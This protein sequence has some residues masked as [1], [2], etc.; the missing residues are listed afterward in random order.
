MTKIATLNFFV[1]LPG[2]VLADDDL[3]ALDFRVL[4]VVAAHDRM[5]RNGQCCWAGQKKLAGLANC[6]PTRLSASLSKLVSKGYLEALRDENDKRRKGFRVIYIAADDAP[7]I[8]CAAKADALRNGNVSEE[9]T[10][11]TGNLS[12]RDSLPKPH[13]SA[14]AATRKSVINH[15]VKSSLPNPNIF[16]ETE[17][18][19]Q[20]RCSG[21]G[22]RPTDR[23]LAD[24]LGAGDSAAGWTL[25]AALPD[26][27][28]RMLRDRWAEGA[29]DAGDLGRAREVAAQMH[30][31]GMKIRAGV[32]P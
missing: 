30:G 17:H 23:A 29:L 8:G 31:S 16:R 14:R 12:S 20:K 3:T 5:G 7:G 11:P 15:V 1:A 32:L 10:L 4:G 9:D 24:L 2:R 27:E 22:A 13:L 19:T 18:I 25:L 21:G 26:K 28:V 6:D